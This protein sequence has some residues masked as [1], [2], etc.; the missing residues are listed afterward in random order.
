[1]T[2]H[3][4]V[5]LLYLKNQIKE[6][7]ANG[8]PQNNIIIYNNYGTKEKNHKLCFNCFNYKT[9]KKNQ[10]LRNIVIIDEI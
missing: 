3:F 9:T 10:E 6:K 4:K 2:A 7:N 8:I 1:M 5:V